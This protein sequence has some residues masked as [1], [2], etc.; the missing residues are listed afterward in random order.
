MTGKMY[1]TVYRGGVLRSTE[2]IE[3]FDSDND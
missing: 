3:A 2:G 1:A